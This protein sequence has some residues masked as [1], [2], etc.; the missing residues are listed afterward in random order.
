[1]TNKRVIYTR[2]DGGVAVL[3]PAPQCLWV[4]QEGGGIWFCSAH[5]WGLQVFMREHL[6]LPK[7]LLDEINTTGMLPVWVARVW[8]IH[9]FVQDSKWRPGCPRR[10]AIATRWID[11]LIHG[12][13]DEHEAIALIIDKDVPAD[14]KAVAVIDASDLPPRTHRNAWRRSP[15]GG[16]IWIDEQKVLAIDEARMWLAY[17]ATHPTAHTGAPA[18]YPAQGLGRPTPAYNSATTNARCGSFQ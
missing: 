3:C 6:K 7:D 4:L 8:E 11:A 1:M 13:C 12:G 9:K 14:A 17:E 10:E 2:P 5:R 16:P 15:N 18:T